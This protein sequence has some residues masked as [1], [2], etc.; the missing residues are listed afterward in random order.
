MEQ[1]NLKYQFLK[2]KNRGFCLHFFRVYNKARN[3]IMLVV[4]L[5]TILVQ[6]K[7]QNWRM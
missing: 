2:Q 6:N 1:K 7:N 4:E 5:V 3:V